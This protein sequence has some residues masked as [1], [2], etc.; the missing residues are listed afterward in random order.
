M[1]SSR[2]RFVV[3]ST[4]AVASLSLFPAGVRAAEFECK[5][6]TLVGPSDP[7]ARKVVATIPVGKRPRGIR[8]SPDGSTLYVSDSSRHVYAFTVS[9]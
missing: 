8:V 1:K 5:F 9:G 7:K 4:A 6:G 3:R 2:Q